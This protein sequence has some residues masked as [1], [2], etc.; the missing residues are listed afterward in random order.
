MTRPMY[1]TL[2]EN[3]NP[4]PSDVRTTNAFARNR[5]VNRTDVRG[6]TV[7]T[8]FLV[9]DHSFSNTGPPILFETMV[10]G[11]PLD[12][13]QERCATWAEAQAMHERMVARVLEAT[14]DEQ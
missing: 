6:S 10:F 12:G 13:E 8:V 4:V 11:G 3:H 1:Y 14:R 9:I 2:D 7:S 5:T